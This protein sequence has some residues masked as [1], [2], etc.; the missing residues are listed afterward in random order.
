MDLDEAIQKHAEWKVRLR[1]AAGR[2]ETLDAATI[3]QDN[4]CIL[5]KWLHGEGKTQY[6]RKASF[7]HLVVKHADFHHSAG[8]V[9]E[10]INAKKY[11]AAETMLGAG[12][13]YG[14]ASL[15]VAA[16]I[17]ALKKEM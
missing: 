7:A 5:G 11:N 8:K 6:G 16:A 14:N 13:Q 15:A 10:A 1:A 9:A 4:A 2:K 17:T 3:G 12:S